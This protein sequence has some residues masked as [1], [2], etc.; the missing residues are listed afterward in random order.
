M[1]TKAENKI[2]NQFP[3]I[4]CVKVITPTPAGIKNREIF[5]VS[6]KEI[7][8]TLL[9]FII[10]KRRAKKNNTIPIT[11]PGMLLQK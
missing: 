4:I 5:E 2:K 9:G 1:L 8:F 3:E 10:L 7:F 6:N 11:L